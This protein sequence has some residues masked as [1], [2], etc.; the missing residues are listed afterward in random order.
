MSYTTN[1]PQ[2]TFT[3]VGFVAP[4]E[5]AI[6]DGVQADYA[7]AFGSNLNPALNTP[8]GQLGTST[9]AIISDVNDQF[10]LLTQNMDPAYASGRF[11]DGI[12]RIYFLTRNPAEPTVLEITCG[13]L[14]GAVVPVGTA[15][16]QDP[17]GNI[18]S[19]TQAG[20]FSSAGT[21]TLGF[22]CQTTGPTPVPE[23]VSIYQS[24]FGWNT[25]VVASGEVGNVVESRAAFEARRQ[26]TV[27]ANA[28]GILDSVLGAVYEVPGVLSAFVT[29][30]DTSSPLVVQGVTLQGNSLYVAAYGGAAAEVAYAIWTKKNPGCGYNGNTTIDVQDPNPAYGGSGPTYAVKFTTPTAEP[31]CFNVTLKNSASV[32]SNV[33]QLVQGGLLAGFTGADGGARA[34]IA[35]TVYASRYYGDV[36]ALGPWVNIETI[37]LGCNNNPNASFTGSIAAGTLDVTAV[38]FG[39]LAVGQFVYGTTVPVAS[40]SSIVSQLTGTPGLV[41]TY[42]LAVN[43]TTA[44]QTMTS[45]AADDNLAVLNADQIPTFATADIAVTLV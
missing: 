6:L 7:S 19:C 28:Q 12:G 1:V 11:Q 9:T 44:S 32:P 27:A 4:P 2:P 29:E 16:V 33:L 35:A 34:G 38:T 36:A 23:T 15:Q 45:V 5:S 41:G 24:V 21:V 26:A 20:T 22:A 3:P 37:Q 18:Y 8:Q 40:G 14:S 10:V 31:V 43:Q 30:N 25:A 42:L 17:S 13:G 39:P